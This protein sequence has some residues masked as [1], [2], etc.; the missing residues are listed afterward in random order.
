MSKRCPYCGLVL[1]E[2]HTVAQCQK[3]E[4]AKKPKPV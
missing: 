4:R 1:N 3:M 2:K